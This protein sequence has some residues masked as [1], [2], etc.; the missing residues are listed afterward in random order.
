MLEN[1]VGMLCTG[2]RDAFRFVYPKSHIS[3]GR[4]PRELADGKHLSP[5]NQGNK[6]FIIPNKL[7][8]RRSGKVVCCSHIWSI[9]ER[10]ERDLIMVRI[11]MLVLGEIWSCEGWTTF[12]ILHTCSVWANHRHCYYRSMRHNTYLTTL[13]WVNCKLTFKIWQENWKCPCSSSKWNIFALAYLIQLVQIQQFLFNM[14][15]LEWTSL[16]RQKYPNIYI[17]KKKTFDFIDNNHIK[18]FIWN[19]WDRQ[20]S[21]MVNDLWCQVLKW[22]IAEFRYL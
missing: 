14:R 7:H 11:E 5:Y 10:L 8:H 12:D 17:W 4:C 15:Y 20:Y 16:W 13:T 21:D 18:L 1:T 9:S 19:I 3:R 2:C 22:E 6:L